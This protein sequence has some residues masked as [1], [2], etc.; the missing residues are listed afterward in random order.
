MGAFSRKI[1]T[2]VVSSLAI[3]TSLLLA[4]CAQEPATERFVMGRWTA[5]IIAGKQADQ[6]ALL[7]HTLEFDP[8][9]ELRV[10]IRL[11]ESPDQVVKR[12]GR[13][14]IKEK[15]RM[16]IELDGQ[17]YTTQAERVE[18]RLHLAQDPTLITLFAFEGNAQDV[19]YVR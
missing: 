14:A 19:F 17:K 15:G 10:L 3:C 1:F 7:N 8:K 16:E 11:K 2:T 5:Y 18:Y 9:G 6:T 13:W 4:G 12:V